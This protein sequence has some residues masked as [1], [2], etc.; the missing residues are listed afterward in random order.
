[1]RCLIYA[2][3]SKDARGESRSVTEQT[4]ECRA[5]ADRENWTIVDVIDEAGSAS[6][7]ARSTGARSRWDEVTTAI[8]T[9]NY[10]ALLTWES[11]RATRD[12]ADYADLRDLCAKH[13]VKWGYSGTL[14][15]LD[16]RT[17]RFRTGLDA[18]MAED[19]AARTSER[20]RRAARARAIAGTPHGKIPYGYRREYDPG[21]GH[22]LQQVPDEITA[23]IVREIYQRI[24]HGDSLR[25]IAANLTARSVTPPRPART[26]RQPGWIPSTVKRIATNPAYAGRR[27]HQGKVIGDAAWEQLVD[28]DTH[29]QVVAILANPA[30]LSKHTK[31]V[32]H[33]LSGIARC[34]VCTRPLY[35]LSNRGRPSYQCVATGCLKVARRVTKIDDHVLGTL[36][37][38]LSEHADELVAH[39]RTDDLQV[40]TARADAKALRDRLD[41]FV[42]QAA[43][44]GPGALSPAALARVEARLTP[45]IQA[46]ERRVRALLVPSVLDD[47]DLS[48]PVAAVDEM[49]LAKKRLVIGTLLDIRVDPVGRGR[50]TFDPGSVRIK[51][52][53]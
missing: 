31:T 25:T 6:R 33:L 36:I 3:V 44:G 1:M 34:G 42:D 10:D 8:A 35:V 53:W 20:V 50:R 37:G 12:L 15:D 28:A 26:D 17:D 39:D 40:Q 51:P 9:G 13:G 48:D 30:R 32:K 21:T 38:L 5:W 19:E 45:Q 29:D 7:Y 24:I 23:P 2:R 52:L 27:V 49:S 16:A 47:V 43:D 41:A 18:L 14:Y 46:A 11:S 4:A 22:L